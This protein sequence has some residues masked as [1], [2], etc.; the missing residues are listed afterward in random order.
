MFEVW[1]KLPKFEKVLVFFWILALMFLF[2]GTVF[3]IVRLVVTALV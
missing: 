2:A 3:F 1:K